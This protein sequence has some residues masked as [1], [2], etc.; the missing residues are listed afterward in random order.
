MPP[1]VL[2]GVIL[3]AFSQRLRV[4]TEVPTLLAASL[5]LRCGVDGSAELETEGVLAGKFFLIEISVC[6]KGELAALLPKSM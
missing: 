1:L 2:M 6:A 4:S 3:P 5:I